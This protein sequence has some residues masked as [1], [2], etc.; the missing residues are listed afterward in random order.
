[1]FSFPL[2]FNGVQG[3]CLFVLRNRI[4]MKCSFVQKQSVS[5]VIYVHYILKLTPCFLS[6]VLTFDHQI[7]RCHHLQ[8]HPPPLLGPAQGRDRL[9]LPQLEGQGLGCRLRARRQRHRL[10]V[11]LSFTKGSVIAEDGVVHIF[12]F[13]VKS[14]FLSSLSILCPLITSVNTLIK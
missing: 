7:G 1:M 8:P 5:C 4:G 14:V 12:F 2:L 6:I 13:F 11:N 10:P 3:C 9:V